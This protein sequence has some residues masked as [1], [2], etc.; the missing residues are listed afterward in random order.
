[1][2]APS[3]LAG[4]RTRRYRRRLASSLSELVTRLVRALDEAPATS[5]R[6]AGLRGSAAALCLA[7]AVSERPQP[8][9]VTLPSGAEAE[10]FAADVR[11]YIGDAPLGSPLARRVHHLP[12]PEVPPFESVSPTR[13][14]VAARM[15]G[16]YHLVQTPA[17]VVVTSAQAW[18]QRCLPR[19]AFDEGVT[20]VVRG[21]SVPPDALV[22]RLVDWGY[23]RVPLVQDPGD[24]ALRGGILDVFPA[25]Y[26][27]P[28][29]LEFAG[30]TVETLRAFDVAS[31]RSLDGVEEVLLLPVR[32]YALSRL[33]PEAARRIDARAAELG[34][35]RQE[36]RDLVEAVRTGL[37]LPGL[38]E[39]LPYLYDEPATLADY[40]PPGALLWNQEAGAV[41]AAVET[42]WI[43]LGS[44]AA[45]A[46]AD[47]RFHPPLEAL[48][49]RPSA[50]RTA[51]ASR[52]R[53]ESEMLDA[54]DG[55]ALRATT[56]ATEGL[57]LRTAPGADGPLAAVA[58]RLAAWE[59]DGTRLVLVG[60]TASQRDR[61][62]AL[63]G[64]HRLAIAASGARFPQALSARDP[65]ALVG[66]LTRGAWLPEDRL[67]IV[68]E[69][70]IFG[71]RRQVRRGRRERPVD[72]LSSLA[73]LKPNDYVVHVDHGIAVYRG[74]RHM[75]VA[76][77]EGDYLH[78]EYAGADRLYLP[79][80]R[81]D[82]VQRYVS[83]DGAAPSLD[84]LGGTS[85]E[86]V[87]AK[88]RESLLAMAR[89]LVELYA[90]RE[91]HGRTG[92]G[93]SDGLAAEF[94]ARFAFEETPD[95]QR[96]IDDVFADLG[97]EKPMDRLI[98]GDVGYGKTEVA[99][100]AAWVVVLA[101]RQVA[102]LVPTTVLA[103]Q[104]LETF[105]ARFEG[106]PVTVE[107]LSRFRS[108]AENRATLERVASG[109][110]DIVIGTHRLLQRDVTFRQLGLLI[111]DEEHRFGVK[112]KERI[113]QLKPTA[114]VLTLTATP[115]PR[116]LNMALS[117]IRDL[118]V[119]ET[120]PVDRLAI[121][122]YVTRHDEG[123]IRDAVV[124]ELG[125]GGQVF[126]VHNRVE[127]IAG[128]ARRLGEIVPEARIAVAH[129]QMA[130]R[131]L[132][133]TMLD[134]MHGKTNVLVCSAIVE[135]GLDIPTANTMIINRADTF[136][137][138]QLYQL[139]GRIGRS[140]HR[141]Y[142]YLLIPGEH[143]I[144]PDAQKRL[145]VLQ[146]LDDLG[147]GFRL[148]AH[149]LEL[150]GAGNLLGKQQSGHIAAVGLELYTHMLEQA[151]RELRGEPTETDIE[152]ELQLG[153]TAYIPETYISDVSQRLMV[154]KRMA[155]IRGVPDLDA[156]A[157]EL[158]DRYGPIPPLVD[159]LLR[160][161]ELRRWL[162]D[163]RV[164]RARRRGDAVVLEFDTT[165][166][167]RTETLLSSIRG[168]RGHL[169][170]AGS[171]AIEIRS[172]AS[173][174]DGLIAELREH[175]QKL[176]AA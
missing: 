119:I 50:W 79:V 159:T 91:A 15:E 27:R 74:L 41:E 124:R 29:R 7:R 146:E 167:V 40:V 129:G 154:Y 139:R 121:R 115:I 68:T 132:E 162:K 172:V 137:L 117:G 8:V 25:G 61:I 128:V 165:T 85:W 164:T 101:G 93:E 32:E 148:A 72:F 78:L 94:A 123:V 168:S 75:Q 30:D 155:G 2:I 147:G 36:R 4:V 39:L 136:G 43:Q 13:E 83:A 157:A 161:M 143:L 96:A 21:E 10:A 156:I 102:V 14:T 54:V 153:I 122:T 9:V 90:A 66:E 80:D 17:P 166:P 86:R 48:Y 20:Y 69:S 105:R 113:R 133:R 104:H 140:H 114:D 130:E 88:T 18:M 110:V 138:A 49:V 108:T 111:V 126:F 35:A 45:A 142:A 81:I 175:L 73:E 106:T 116:T 71:E 63:L 42:A 5:V 170:M 28:L 59:R 53:V 84:K 163:L 38:E 26:E 131:E 176:A 171:S 160:V 99:M 3:A 152:P 174:H 70:E 145:R 144:T 98:C 46:A 134:F 135:S 95:Q 92:Y 109:Q 31:Q 56:Y 58:A 52:P 125:R 87:K 77:T 65:V 82:L 24:L 89:E 112:A 151:V 64:G 150:R 158:V 173:D 57:A 103:Q 97:R 16:L 100:R 33:G 62:V 51:I 47:G 44:Q 19:A 118:S 23:H 149:D 76:D 34:L 120:P 67:A 11:F 60:A 12:A 1:V 22:T 169:R 141:A 107:M 6:V 55:G 37:V 127:N